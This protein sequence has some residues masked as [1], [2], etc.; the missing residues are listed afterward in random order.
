MSGTSQSSQNFDAFLSML[1][2]GC[3]D[4]STSLNNLTSAA[5]S[6]N[7][8]STLAG[9]FGT[10]VGAYAAKSGATPRQAIAIGTTATYVAGAVIANSAQ[11][12]AGTTA[13]VQQQIATQGM[14]TQATMSAYGSFFGAIAD[15]VSA[16]DVK[17]GSPHTATRPQTLANGIRRRAT[18]YD[19]HGQ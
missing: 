9:G 3:I 7:F 2:E 15:L 16:S 19:N 8:G 5:P 1:D 12:A 10:A 17:V 14:T 4:F 6:S 11:I 13:L 18:I